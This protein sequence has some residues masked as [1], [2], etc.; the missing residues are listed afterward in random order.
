MTRWGKDKHGV[1]GKK[2]IM[3]W[4]LHDSKELRLYHVPSDS[5]IL[6]RYRIIWGSLFKHICILPVM[7][8]ESVVAGPG[9]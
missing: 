4:F 6:V 2:Q 5:D 9:H 3:G 7:A 1:G 8:S